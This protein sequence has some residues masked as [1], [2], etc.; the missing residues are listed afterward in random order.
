MRFA[1]HKK[2]LLVAATIA[3]TFAWSACALAMTYSDAMALASAAIK[4]NDTQALT[5]LQAVA[6][7][8]DVNAESWLGAYFFSRKD[9]AKALPLLR[10]AADQGNALAQ[11]ILAFMYGN[12]QG[13]PQDDSEAVKWFRKAAEQGNADGQYNLGVMYKNGQGVPQ[14]YSEAVK[15]YRKAADQGDALAQNNL[16]VMYR[17][18]QGVRQSLVLAYAL[19][20]SAAA[21]GNKQAVDNRNALGQTLSEAQMEAGQALTRRMQKE[22][23]LKVMDAYLRTV[24]NTPHARPERTSSRAPESQD[25]PWPT[26]PAHR[27]GVTSCNTRCVNGSCWRTYDDGRHVRL[28]VPPT[29]DPFSGQLTFKTPPC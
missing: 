4:N 12:G 24:G 17:N 13:V 26:R 22:G 8:G 6:Q 2:P 28:N 3:V 20:N 7:S 29:M 9:Y 15:W 27:P 5:K 14:D 23:L 16:G 21:G 11:N 25:G 1:M 18:G 10:K 19:Y